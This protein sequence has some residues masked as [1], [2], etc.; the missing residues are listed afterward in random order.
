MQIFNS[1]SYTFQLLIVANHGA[2]VW[3]IAERSGHSR[4]M[5]ENRY[6]HMFPEK[7]KKM[8]KLHIYKIF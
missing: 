6:S 2:D 7:R 4:E 3:D 1:L 5:V 8:K